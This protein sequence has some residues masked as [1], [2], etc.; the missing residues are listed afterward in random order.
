MVAS[1]RLLSDPLLTVFMEAGLVGQLIGVCW[2]LNR[3][4]LSNSFEIKLLR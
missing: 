4:R 2:D 3:V 1:T